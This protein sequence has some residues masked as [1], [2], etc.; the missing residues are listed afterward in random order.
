[1]KQIL[2]LLA[3]AMTSCGTGKKALHYSFPAEWEAQ[4]SVWLGWSMDSSVQQVHL[5]MALALHERVGLTVLLRSDS[6]RE[7]ALRQLHEA[8]IDTSRVV[9]YLHYIPNLFIRD[10]GPRF[11]KSPRGNLAIADPGWNN[12]GYPSS[13]AVYQF[14]DRRGEIDNDLARQMNLPLISSSVVSEGGGIE[15]SSEMLICFRET[16]LQRNPGLQ[17]PEIEKEYL[18]IYGKKKM[19]WLN[20]MP[21]MDKVVE[22]AKAGNYFGYG[23]NGHTD[24]FVRFVN[25]STILVA[26]ID[27]AE[28]NDNPVSEL[29]YGI[30]EENLQILR[31]ARD[32]RGRPF[33]VIVL[34]VPAYS[35][36]VEKQVLTDLDLNQGD[37]RVLFRNHQAGDEICW[38]PAVSYLN[39]LISNGVI[40]A[41]RYWQPGLPDSERKKDE[42]VLGILQAQF[43]G[44]SIVQI[45]PLALNKYGGGMHC[46]SQQQPAVE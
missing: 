15:A 37:G 13:L 5:Q 32:V 7:V 44:Y 34:P 19:I 3:L 9:T 4:S 45:N 20:K 12:Y 16:A 2:G 14:S 6:L 1:M 35:Q 42:R 8:G 40:L 33:R 11:L 41:A 31:E 30:L 24:E 18:R 38:L 46:A 27:P 36:Y 23:A 22:G 28:K 26:G 21:I 25:D 10:A 39:F 43:P 17:L 29:D